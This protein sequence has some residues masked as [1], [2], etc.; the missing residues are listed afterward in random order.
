MQITDYPLTLN[1][2]QVAEILGVSLPK[3]YDIIR[4]KV[5]PAL[6]DGNR[7][8]IPRDRFWEWYNAAA[9]KASVS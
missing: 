1:A 3:A 9:E 8:M 6:K 4:R 2:K 5:F 7:L